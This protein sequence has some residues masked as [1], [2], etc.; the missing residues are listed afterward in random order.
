MADTQQIKDIAT[1]AAEFANLKKEMLDNE[2]RIKTLEDYRAK[3]ERYGFFLMGM[4][5]VGTMLISSVEGVVNKIIAVI[6]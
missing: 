5:A 6:K 4:V 2:S 3:T 1:I